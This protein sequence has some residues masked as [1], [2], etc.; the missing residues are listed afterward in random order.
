MAP[1]ALTGI[2]PPTASWPMQ[3]AAATRRRAARTWFFFTGTI[4]QF[5]FFCLFACGWKLT[6]RSVPFVPGFV[7]M[8]YS[9]CSLAACV[10]C[11]CMN[12]VFIACRRPKSMEAVLR[13]SDHHRCCMD[14]PNAFSITSA[15]VPF[16]TACGGPYMCTK[17]N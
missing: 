6:S 3:A 12:S 8:L 9:C 11:S 13:F 15:L 16:L 7:C 14:R 2:M 1:T 4:V 5:S 10:S 17:G